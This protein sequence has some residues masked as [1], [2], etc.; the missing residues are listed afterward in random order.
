M[1]VESVYDAIETQFLTF[2]TGGGGTFPGSM[3]VINETYVP[4]AGIPYIVG[5]MAAYTRRALTLGTDKMILSGG[6]LAEHQGLYRMEAVVPQDAGRPIATQ[7][8]TQLLRLFPR[9]MTLIGSDGAQV[10]FDA[11][12]ALPIIGQEGWYRAP[13]Q[14]PWY[15][16]EAS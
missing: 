3:V 4:T 12:A 16:F 13:I 10:N 7:F 14:C 9:G 5:T 6:Y 8:Q 11:P 1:S 15:Y 2:G